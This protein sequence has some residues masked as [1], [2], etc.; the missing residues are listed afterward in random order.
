MNFLNITDANGERRWVIISTNNYRDRDGEII[1]LESHVKDCDRMRESGDYGALNWWHV[2]AEKSG[3]DFE[4]TSLRG[5]TFDEYTQK[6]QDGTLTTVNLGPC[7]YSEMFDGFRVESGTY[8]SDEAAD[9]VA[10][11]GGELKVSPEFFSSGVD[12]ELVHGEIF[13]INR[14]LL[15]AAAPANLLTSTI[16]ELDMNPL[17]KLKS[18][19]GNNEAADVVAKVADLDQA[20]LAQKLESKEVTEAAPA[21]EKETTSEVEPTQSTDGEGEVLIAETLSVLATAIGE[22]GNR[23]E[24]LGADV[25]AIKEAQAADSAKAT[26]GVNAMIEAQAAQIKELAASVKSLADGAP[27]GVLNQLMASAKSVTDESVAAE[28]V[29]KEVSGKVEPV[30][31]FKSFASDWAV[32][33]NGN[34]AQYA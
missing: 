18:L 4:L 31:S 30:S 1:P 11:Y 34:D 7:D 9:L 5:M 22:L 25:A 13:T 33:Q 16:K 2:Y 10:G 20:A 28:A 19:I 26:E 14:S 15:P 17:D 6:T 27:S 12:D 8:T 3:D 32:G 29:E 23:F 21:V 24:V